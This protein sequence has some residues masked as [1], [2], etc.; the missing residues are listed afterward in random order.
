MEWNPSNP[1]QRQHGSVQ[2]F[3]V[4]ARHRSVPFS[5]PPQERN[6]RTEL[7]ISVLGTIF[8]LGELWELFRNYF[9]FGLI[10]QV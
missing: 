8:Q 2:C 10:T 1:G 7:P 5:V 6:G 9:S 4:P 3:P